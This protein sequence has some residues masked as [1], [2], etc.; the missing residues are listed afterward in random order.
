MIENAADNKVSEGVDPA[1]NNPGWNTIKKHCPNL[2]KVELCGVN[3]PDWVKKCINCI[4]KA[5]G[6]LTIDGTIRNWIDIYGDV[7]KGATK[8]AK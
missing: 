2:A 6:H 8:G 5:K 3:V 1:T 4:Q 7:I